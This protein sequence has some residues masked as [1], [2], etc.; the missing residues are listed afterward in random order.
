MRLIRQW[1]DTSNPNSELAARYLT[2]ILWVIGS[3]YLM[4]FEWNKN[5]FDFIVFI[6]TPIIWAAV[7]SL[8]ILSLFA[9]RNKRILASLLIG[10]S[11][12][13]GSIYTATNTISRQSIQRDSNI[14][15][16]DRD[17]KHR[18]ALEK[19]LARNQK[20]LNEELD[21][22]R[23]KCD[24]N[25]KFDCEQIEVSISVYERAVK[26]DK[27]DLKEIG[28]PISLLAGESRI[29]LFIA[30]LTGND[31]SNM[32]QFVALVQPSIFGVFIELTAMALAL[33]G[34]HN[35]GFLTQ[36]TFSSR[37]SDR[38]FRIDVLEHQLRVANQ[39]NNHIDTRVL[40]KQLEDAKRQL[41]KE[42]E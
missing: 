39:T 32:R 37:L 23:R 10:L 5:P 9:W 33:Y 7:I 8:P 6:S 4:A 1:F 19:S 2:L 17:K 38:T 31:E 30:K 11:A 20:M 12:I 25:P 34:W 16:Q 15:N 3:I 21:L 35:Y 36:H 22:K 40:T 28:K 26:S 29:A 24:V 41:R 14:D 27:A 18:D 42:L 13:V